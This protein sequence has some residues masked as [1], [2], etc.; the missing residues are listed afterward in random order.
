MLLAGFL[1]ITLEATNKINILHRPNKNTSSKAEEAKTTS[2]A[3]TAQEDFQGGDDRKPNTT[4]HEEGTVKDTQGNV[5]AIPPSTQWSTSQSGLITI[6]TPAKN[7]V[8][9]TGLIVSGKASVPKVSFRLIDNVSGVISRGELSVING[10]YSGVF[11]FTTTAT[12]G[13]LDIFSTA[14][15]GVE[16]NNITVSIR[17]K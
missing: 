8:V 5:G 12:A 16:S 17:F 2:D 7:T 9:A 10:A 1:F 11:N 4:S 13:R 3:A 14:A 6:Y 15:D